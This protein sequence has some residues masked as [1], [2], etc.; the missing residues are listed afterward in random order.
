MSPI[1]LDA[2]AVLAAILHERGHERVL[3]LGDA[4]HVSTVNMSEARVRLWDLGYSI[5]DIDLALENVD[6]TV[7]DFTAE[8][9][10][11]AGDL[12]PVTRK[13]GLSLGDRACLAL[14]IELGGTALTADRIW[15]SL[16][17]PVS[18]ELIR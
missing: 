14:A 9:A 4:G 8:H 12:R 5:E 1:V 18:I 6:A 17:L 7:V 3:A 11:L 2:S 15:A 16:D 13:A 10:R